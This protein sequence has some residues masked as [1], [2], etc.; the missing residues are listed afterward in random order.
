MSKQVANTDDFL[1]TEKRR[2]ILQKIT[3][4]KTAQEVEQLLEEYYPGWLV[5]S[6]DKY[7]DDYPH[8]A[9]NWKVMCQSLRVPTQKIVLVADIKF[10]EEHSIINAVSEFMTKNGYCVRRAGEFIACPTCEAAIP[11]EQ[12]WFLLK[13]KRF[14][15]PNSWQNKCSGC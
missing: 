15:V 5:F 7:S 9:K 12:I 3:E 1:D 2:E 6:L 8:L 4:K 10:D 14:P 11:C 13:D